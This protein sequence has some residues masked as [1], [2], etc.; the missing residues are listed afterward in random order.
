MV[1]KKV[2]C[3]RH[4]G[5]KKN[6]AKMHTK[7]LKLKRI[8]KN[9]PIRNKIRT[10]YQVI[11]PNVCFRLPKHVGIYF[12]TCATCATAKI[13]GT[14]WGV[15]AKATGSPRHDLFA[16]I[17]PH[18]NIFCRR[19]PGDIMAASAYVPYSEFQ[20]FRTFEVPTLL[21]CRTFTHT[22]PNTFVSFGG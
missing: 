10:Y 22:Y 12:A 7:N 16:H 5:I 18:A 13:K 14:L 1:T 2:L 8:P 20:L 11:C 4:N 15:D 6:A 9:A 19:T 17:Y 3:T 21:P